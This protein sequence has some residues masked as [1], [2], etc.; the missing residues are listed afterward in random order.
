MAAQASVG[1]GTALLKPAAAIEAG[2]R[3]VFEPVVVLND[4]DL[5]GEFTMSV[6][7]NETQEV[8]KPQAEW[9]EFSA[10]KFALE[11]G[12][13]KR[14][15]VSL[16][17]PPDAPIG[18]YF[19]YIEAAVYRAETQGAS[20]VSAVSASKLSFAVTSAVQQSPESIP[21]VAPAAMPLQPLW[22]ASFDPKPKENA[23]LSELL[24][25]NMFT[26]ITLKSPVV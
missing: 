4:G 9:L 7:F 22:P 3:H 25:G 18:E 26:N 23:K 14:V 19:A 10:Q 6:T 20:R 12:E 21:D 17:L 24:S 13:S 16:Q 15:M 8:Y 5:A 1:I 2:K 11:P